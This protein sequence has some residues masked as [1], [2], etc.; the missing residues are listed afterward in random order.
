[1]FSLL[2]QYWDMLPQTEAFK[3]EMNNS[4]KAHFCRQLHNRE[5]ISSMFQLAE[6]VLFSKNAK[7]ACQ[8]P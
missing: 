2:C 7:I 1:M 8:L 5:S 3:F 6:S 4:W